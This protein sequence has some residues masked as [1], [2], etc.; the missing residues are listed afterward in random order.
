MHV[1]IIHIKS[2]IELPTKDLSKQ[3]LDILSKYCAP[4]HTRQHTHFYDLV[5]RTESGATRQP[6][7]PFP[8]STTDPGGLQTEK[9]PKAQVEIETTNDDVRACLRNA[10]STLRLTSANVKIQAGTQS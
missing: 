4:A 1:Y 10:S 2:I 8:K 3:L 5:Y 9:G 7:L 6:R